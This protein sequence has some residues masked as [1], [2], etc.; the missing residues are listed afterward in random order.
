MKIVDVK[1]H[2]IYL[3]EGL[4]IGSMPPMKNSGV[5]IQIITDEGIEG[6]GVSHFAS[7]GM[8]LK[9]LLDE[10]FKG[11]LPGKDPFMVDM[12]FDEI[13]N[14]TNRIMYGMPQATSMIQ[15]A[16]MDIIGKA[17]KQPIYKLMGG[18][19]KEVKAYISLNYTESPESTVE[20]VQRA[21]D[22]GGY[23][24]VKLRI[25]QGIRK[26]EMVVKAVR[27]TYP[28]MDIMVDANSA[29]KTVVEAVKL[30]KTLDKY[31]L[32]WIEEPLASDNLNGHARLRELSQVPIAGGE[33][34]YGL[35]RFEDI[36]SRGC[37][38]IIQPDVTRCGGPWEVKKIDA[39]A[40][41]RGVSCIPHTWGYGHVMAANLHN[42]MASRCEYFEFPN[43]PANF[44]FLEEPIKAVDGFV[45]ALERPGLG[46]EINQELFE[47][48]KKA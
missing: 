32:A 9:I 11:Y 1:T 36:L 28:E 42:I 5:F 6:W 13:N 20:T 29:Y 39:L 48:F 12:I 38:D 34:D 19:K 41:V 18:R 25:G 46:V 30:V 22:E 37:Y 14:Y 33:N 31:D 24:A 17:T 21:I 8:A 45:P 7:S 10:Y 16:L 43:Y 4:K 35:F 44:Q 40:E 15:I 23:Q 26:D 2:L 3:G 47:N 27:E